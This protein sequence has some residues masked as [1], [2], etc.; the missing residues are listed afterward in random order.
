MKAYST[1]GGTNRGVVRNSSEVII[2]PVYLELIS[3]Q[4]KPYI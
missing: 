3:P 4:L 1:P 2:I